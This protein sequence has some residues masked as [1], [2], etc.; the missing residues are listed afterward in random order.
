MRDGNRMRMG[1]VRGERASAGRLDGEGEKP[2]EIAERRP[3]KQ[4]RA[5]N[6]L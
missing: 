6:D 2:C 5:A 3:F 1:P 4:Y